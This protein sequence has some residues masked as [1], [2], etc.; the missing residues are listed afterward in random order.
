[1]ADKI[2]W[3]YAQ[4]EEYESIIRDF[5]S[6][7]PDTSLLEAAKYLHLQQLDPPEG[8]DASVPPSVNDFGRY[9]QRLGC[10]VYVESLLAEIAARKE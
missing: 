2:K 3:Y 8:Y 9:I 5:I 6:A 4:V 1:M 10:A 7:F